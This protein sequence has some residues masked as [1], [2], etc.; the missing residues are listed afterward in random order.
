MFEVLKRNGLARSGNWLIEEQDK[1]VK[2]PNILFLNTN[3]IKAP[4]EAE[5][6][7][8]DSKATSDKPYI[9]SGHSLFLNQ[10]DEI[11]EYT[12]SPYLVYPPSQTEL[13]VFASK[14]NMESLK[15]KI[16]VVTGKD[17]SIADSVSDVDAE[18]FVLT[19][20]LHL[21]TRPISFANTLMNLRKAIGYQKLIYTPGLG[22][23]SHIA[24]LA[25][26]GIDLMDSTPLF[27][28]ARLSNY[29][30]PHGKIVK[31]DLTE[32]FC[33]CSSC[34]GDKKD[35]NSILDHNY[36]V[37]LSEFGIV[38][39]AIRKGQLRELVEARARSEPWMVSVL[40]ILDRD[41][42]PF[43]ERNL[44]VS[45]GPLIATTNDSL[46]R[47]EIVR[48]R[49]RV[50]NRYKKP[51]SKKILLLLPCSAK[52]PYSFSKT[53]RII[54]STMREIAN[55]HAIHE[56]VITSPLGVVPKEVELFYPAQQYDIPVTRC[57]SRDEINMI[58]EDL[59]EFLKKNRYDGIVVHLPRDY[60]FVWDILDDYTNTC[61]DTPLSSSSLEKLKKILTDLV[62]PYDKI[63]K[64]KVN[65]EGMDCFARFQFG[66]A[67]ENLVRDTEVK[68]RYPNIKIIKEKKQIGMLVGE[69]GMISLTLDGAKVLAEENSYRVKIH[70][71]EPKGSI[72]AIGVK[73]ADDDIR[74][75]DDVVVLRDNELVGVGVAQMS[76]DEMVDSDRGEAVKIRHLV[77]SSGGE[78]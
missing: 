69:R 21:I 73:D 76:P 45:G 64:K 26:C 16:M 32:N 24:L 60:E 13:N 54:R 19:N 6:L 27:L 74:I 22:A 23:P 44:P 18:V 15:S 57:W 12:V 78:K 9:T 36:H 3:R 71:F 41:H 61:L 75:G 4:E 1:E 59:L 28:N 52:K 11:N 42:Y 63:N 39:N 31:E 14:L 53:H 17:D 48:F 25:Y 40:R 37:S 65:L 51:P 62:L 33:F 29:L 30:F 58:Q 50:R 70:D 34:C 72:F 77:K 55:S 7:I 56:V 35:F 10:E 49:N 43:L 68:G 66:I 67:G 46:N 8:M 2:T 38:R 5:V 20:A 47:P